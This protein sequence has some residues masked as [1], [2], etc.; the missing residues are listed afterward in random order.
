MI[1]KCGYLQKHVVAALKSGDLG[2]FTDLLNTPAVEEQAREPGFWVNVGRKE[3]DGLTIGELA[4]LHD[5]SACLAVLGKVGVPLDLANTI[6]GYSALHRSVEGVWVNVGSRR[7]VNFIFFLNAQS[8]VIFTFSG[9]LREEQ[10][11]FYK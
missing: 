1:V 10:I 2:T 4:V 7:N 9:R 3:D 6:T 8:I 5:D 11:T